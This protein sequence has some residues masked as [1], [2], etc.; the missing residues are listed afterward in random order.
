L[1]LWQ[2]GAKV[3]EC[4]RCGGRWQVFVDLQHDEPGAPVFIER[5]RSWTLGPTQIRTIRSSASE[6]DRTTTITHEWRQSVRLGNE[7][8]RE[9]SRDVKLGPPLS[10]FTASVEQAVKSHYEI[11]QD[12]SRTETEQITVRNV[13]AGQVST[14]RYQPEYEWRHG[15][16]CVPDKRGRHHRVPV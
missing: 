4:P 15:I 8:A 3:A 5:E 6:L 12:A 11:T 13:P 14:V 7:Q 1:V 9:S 2:A 10:E 16:V